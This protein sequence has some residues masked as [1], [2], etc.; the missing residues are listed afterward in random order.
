MTDMPGSDLPLEPQERPELRFDAPILPGW[1]Q[2]SDGRRLVFLGLVLAV[3][4]V[5]WPEWRAGLTAAACML[6]LAAFGD[7]LNL[8]WRREG[9]LTDRRVLM[10]SHLAGR[11]LP[12]WQRPR[13][14]LYFRSKLQFN[15]LA[16]RR[17]G[18]SVYRLGVLN[19][20]A[21]AALAAALPK[22]NGVPQ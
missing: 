16:S 4:I 12:I 8:V 19:P 5:L 20:E 14:E 11:P 13:E 17:N 2:M 10:V 7:L 22:K 1:S 21:K 15:R 3:I 6:G 9:V 18:L